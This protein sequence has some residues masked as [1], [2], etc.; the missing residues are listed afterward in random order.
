M[1]RAR[2]TNSGKMQS[3][4]ELRRAVSKHENSA[5]IQNLTWNS[6]MNRYDGPDSS[7]FNKRLVSLNSQLKDALARDFVNRPEPQKVADFEREF[8]SYDYQNSDRLLCNNDSHLKALEK[9]LRAYA[10]CVDIMTNL[11]GT[12]K[13]CRHFNCN[14]PVKCNC[15][16]GKKD[17]NNKIL[18]DEVLDNETGFGRRL[19]ITKNKSIIQFDRPATPD[20]IRIAVRNSVTRVVHSRAK[21]DCGSMMRMLMEIDAERHN[22]RSMCASAKTE[23]PTVPIGEQHRAEVPAPDSEEKTVTLGSLA[24][25]VLGIDGSGEGIR[26]H[27]KEYCMIRG[28]ESLG[29]QLAERSFLPM[30]MAF[31]MRSGDTTHLYAKLDGYIKDDLENQARNEARKNGY[32]SEES[33]Y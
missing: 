20:E 11:D 10:Y 23:L 14:A 5:E 13:N 16:Q 28:C 4:A 6:R 8:R 25:N 18:S 30:N 7:A 1:S 26:Q 9:E 15:R 21:D 2:S 12:T 3:T 29:E 22:A 31:S 27:I 33:Y 19:L 17:A 32:E 24:D